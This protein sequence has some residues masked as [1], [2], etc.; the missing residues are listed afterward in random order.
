M[1]DSLRVLLLSTKQRTNMR[2]FGRLIERLTASL[3]SKPNVSNL[4]LVVELS[5]CSCDHWPIDASC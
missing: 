3:K 2:Q 5:A 4:V 1:H